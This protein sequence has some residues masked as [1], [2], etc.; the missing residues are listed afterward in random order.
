VLI[1]IDPKRPNPRNISKA[2]DALK[3]GEIIIY[4]TDTCYGIGGDIFSKKAIEKI[5]EIKRVSKNTPFSFVCPDLKDISKY[6]FVT[7][8]AYRI[9]K[10]YLPGPFTF[11]LEGSREV[12]KLMLTKRRTVG[13]RIPDHSICLAIVETLGNPIITTTASFPDYGIISDPREMQEITGK[14][15]SIII[16]SGIISPSPSTVISLIDKEFTIIRDGG[17]IISP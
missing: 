12:P 8:F 9:M 5:Y 17:H 7:D 15:V 3:N 14:N 6:A 2:V 10:K 13:I 4:P 1:E 11:I 16:D